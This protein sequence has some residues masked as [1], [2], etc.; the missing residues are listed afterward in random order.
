MSPDSIATSVPERP[1]NN[2]RLVGVTIY[3]T[4]LP[5]F[6]RWYEMHDRDVEKGVAELRQLMEGAEGD[7]AFERLERALAGGVR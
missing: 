7:G 4:K 2:A 6:E 3:R 5:L 1:I